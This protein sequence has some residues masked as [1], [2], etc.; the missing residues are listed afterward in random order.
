MRA[1]GRF[2]VAIQLLGLLHDRPGSREGAALTSERMADIVNTNPVVVRR[3]LGRLREAG[4]VSS[5]PGP[6]G[7]WK[8][9][10]SAD[11]I[12]LWD[13]LIAVEHLAPYSFDRT[14][15]GSCCTVGD[16][17]PVVLERCFR[18]AQ[19][20]LASGLDTITVA[21]LSDPATDGELHWG[22]PAGTNVELEVA[23]TTS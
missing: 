12:S 6:G 11:E 20:A 3:I 23:M 13:V 18:G 8:L 17:L 5:Q 19:I 22:V 16:R 2:I 15:S 9:R 21:A 7:G 10:R 14:Q 1:S 4:F